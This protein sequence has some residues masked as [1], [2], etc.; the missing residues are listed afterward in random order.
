MIYID[1]PGFLSKDDVIKVQASEI[2]DLRKE[3]YQHR[4]MAQDHLRRFDELVKEND[5]LRME[6]VD[7][8]ILD[9][10]YRSFIAVHKTNQQMGSPWVVGPFYFLFLALGIAIGI[11]I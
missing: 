5:R 10:T 4:E 3:L 8:S 2:E 9:V 11:C 7:D 6:G 1:K